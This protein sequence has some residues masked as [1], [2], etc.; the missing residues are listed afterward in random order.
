MNVVAA[1]V[2]LFH[3]LQNVLRILQTF[4]GKLVKT[5][6]C[7]C[8]EKVYLNANSYVFSLFLVVSYCE[9]KYL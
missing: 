7:F 6:F 9:Q 2:D 1:L 5:F 4:F 3:T 8:S